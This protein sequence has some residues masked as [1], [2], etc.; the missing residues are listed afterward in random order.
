MKAEPGRTPKIFGPLI[1]G[2][3]A[4][5]GVRIAGPAAP[6]AFCAC[7]AAEAHNPT[8]KKAASRKYFFISAVFPIDE[9]NPPF[10]GF[11]NKSHPPESID[12]NWRDLIRKTQTT[13]RFLAACP[14]F[15]ARPGFTKRAGYAPLR[16][17]DCP[18]AVCEKIWG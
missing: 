8:D 16:L 13:R 5:R 18:P 15:V 1:R 9:G 7:N 10:A 17:L 11:F 6:G 12:C 3:F 4:G 14:S 2:V